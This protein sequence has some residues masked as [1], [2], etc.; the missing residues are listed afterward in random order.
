MP[1]LRCLR[2]RVFAAPGCLAFPLHF[3]LPVAMAA[4]TPVWAYVL[5]AAMVMAGVYL[6]AGLAP[7]FATNPV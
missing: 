4:P 6:V 5:A 1:I 2:Q 7:V 3:W